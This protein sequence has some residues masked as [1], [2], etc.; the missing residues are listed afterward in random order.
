VLFRDRVVRRALDIRRAVSSGS[1]FELDPESAAYLSRIDMS[2]ERC[3]EP[4][5]QDAWRTAIRNVSDETTPYLAPA[6]L[7]DIW[8]R[9]LGSPC[10]EAAGE[11]NK[12][13]AR[14][15]AAIA[16][17]NAPDIVKGGT[18]LLASAPAPSADDLAYLTTV[19]AAAYVRMDEPA[20][21]R[22]LLREEWRRLTHRGQF[23]LALRELAAL[24]R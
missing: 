3:A 18:S 13:W 6:E 12:A 8:N 11:A 5:G 10:Y 15:L 16:Q 14:M 19:T 4:E 9:V 23:D 17:R 24:T 1:L 2:P 21:A 7:A 20:Q 22:S